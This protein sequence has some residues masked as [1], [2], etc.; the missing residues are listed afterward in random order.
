MAPTEAQILNVSA[1]KVDLSN[2]IM[3]LLLQRKY[4]QLESQMSATLGSQFPIDMLQTQWDGLV[5]QIGPYKRTT[6]TKV[7]F[8][9][10]TPIYV[11]HGEFQKALLDLRL[12]FDVTNHLSLLTW[13]PLSALPRVEI[14]A[15]ATAIVSDFF[16][17][18]F[19][20]VWAKFDATLGQLIP[21][22]NLQ[23]IWTQA[24]NSAGSFDHADFGTKS[25]DVD[26][27]G[28]LCQMQGGRLSV[29]VGYDLDMKINTFRMFPS[30]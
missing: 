23:E 25:S 13:T 4:S 20:K 24:T 15:M 3:Q 30:K 8:L 12:A 27:V 9:N 26:L 10:N 21:E 29:Q 6:G 1:N 5:P 28:V 14:E 2:Q 11:V 18:K 19:D 22:G 17:K 7:T 16:L